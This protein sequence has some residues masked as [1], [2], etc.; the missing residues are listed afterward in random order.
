M[1]TVDGDGFLNLMEVAEPR[2]VVPC[3]R[4]MDTVIDKMYCRS[5][6]AVC[7]EMDGLSY[8]GMTT[9]TWTSRS[10]DGYISITVCDA[11]QKSSHS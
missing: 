1:S 2:Y 7:K 6:Q 11:S 8:V 10:G 4:T 5:K 9:D 3:R